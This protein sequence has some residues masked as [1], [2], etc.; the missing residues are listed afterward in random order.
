[1]LSDLGMR[2]WGE[3]DRENERTKVHAWK[4]EEEKKKHEIS[5]T[6]KSYVRS[7]THQNAKCKT[8]T[9]QM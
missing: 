5:A 7:L 1:M 9:S 6:Y 8:T 4:K 2:P 3:E